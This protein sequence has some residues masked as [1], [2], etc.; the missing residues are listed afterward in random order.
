[1]SRYDLD[2]S[3]DSR[4]VQLLPHGNQFTGLDEDEEEN[5]SYQDLLDLEKPLRRNPH[6]QWC[7]DS[8]RTGTR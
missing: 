8:V 3:F 5:M 7:R 2:Y 6:F 1:M 4:K